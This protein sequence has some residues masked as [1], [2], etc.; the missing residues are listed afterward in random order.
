MSMATAMPIASPLTFIKEEVLFFK[1]VSP[2][3]FE[4][5]S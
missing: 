4:I 3:D 2:G 1:Q 5:A